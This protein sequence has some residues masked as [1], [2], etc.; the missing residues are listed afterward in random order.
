[1]HNTVDNGDATIVGCAASATACHRMMI[2]GECDVKG[3]TRNGK[4][5]WE[6]H[7]AMKECTFCN[8]DLCNA[9]LG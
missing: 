5:L 3:Y 9:A 2:N 1:M 8:E 7:L 6:S 4:V